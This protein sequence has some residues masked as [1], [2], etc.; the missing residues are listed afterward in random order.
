V[1]LV[2]EEGYNRGAELVIE[3]RAVL[4]RGEECTFQLLDEGVSRRHVE[5]ERKADRLVVRDLKS[6][7]GTRVNGV[8]VAEAEAVPGDRIAIGGVRLLVAVEPLGASLSERPTAELSPGSAPA[9]VLLPGL[10]EGEILG[11]SAP[12]RTLLAAL[13]KAAPSRAT[14]LVQGESGTGKE[15][16][17]RAV[18]RVSPRRRGPFVVVNG[19]ALPEQLVESEIFGHE[20]G[21][22]TGALARKIGLA[23]AAH[24]GTLFLDELGELSG[25]AQAKLLRFLESGEIV[26]VGATQPIHL[27]VR[28]VAAT[29]RDLD[30]LVKEGRFREDLL[31]R[32]RVIEL[33]VPPLRDRA[34]DVRLLAE[35]FLE[36]FSGG[37]AR[38]T[39]A[40]LE[41][42]AAHRWPG[43][44]R[45]LRNAVEAAFILAG[46]ARIDA[47]DLPERV[48]G[49]EGRAEPRT[50][51]GMEE[52]AIREALR[53]H[54]GNRTQ[55]ARELGIDRK[56]LSTK[57]KEPE[58]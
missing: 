6:R 4:G 58:A 9:V 53:R 46:S 11:E 21:A 8:P 50:L 17:A 45:E 10:D 42:L 51:A 52:R 40:A 19:A 54:G 1:R 3:D 30:A 27:D 36:R 35:R 43:N 48:R 47:T 18:H 12:M 33:R 22:F 41:V 38:F 16:V 20:K 23:E 15:L 29:H 44:V 2:V 26:R 34:G 28:L 57:L 55:A 37:R 56:T 13:A 49:T 14:V 31:Y 5:L 25:A 39:D 7:N 24:G 32:L